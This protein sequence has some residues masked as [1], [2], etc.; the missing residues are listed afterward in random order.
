MVTFPLPHRT[1]ETRHAEE[2]AILESG[3][4]STQVLTLVYRQNIS[5]FNVYEKLIQD[6]VLKVEKRNNQ[7]TAQHQAAQVPCH[8]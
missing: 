3:L 4:R 6:E 7:V 5:V 2:R 8:L 1:L